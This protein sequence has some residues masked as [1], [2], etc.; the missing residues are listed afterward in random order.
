MVASAGTCRGVST[1]VNRESLDQSTVSRLHQSAFWPLPFLIPDSLTG[2]HIA[3]CGNGLYRTDARHLDEKRPTR[4][5]AP[6]DFPEHANR[7][8]SVQF[9]VCGYWWLPSAPGLS[10]DTPA[11]FWGF[12]LKVA[13]RAIER[14]TLGHVSVFGVV[15]RGK[16]GTFCGPWKL[17]TL[18]T[19]LTIAL[20][21]FLG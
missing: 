15:G 4:R 6:P 19:R 1:F 3:G 8:H 16:N 20:S 10:S 9:G 13:D 5:T 21:G 12:G 2:V 17:L 7:P 14:R 11:W 18:G